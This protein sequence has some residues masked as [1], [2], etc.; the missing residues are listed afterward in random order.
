MK[1]LYAMELYKLWKNKRFLLFLMIL[2]LCN[3]VFLSYETWGQGAVPADAYQKL[4]T[5][6]QSLS[7]N[8][9]FVYIKEH[10]HQVELASVEEQ[11]R[12]LKAQHD[13][14]ADLR[15]SALRDQYPDLSQKV[16]EEPLY[17]G[18]LESESAFMK[19]IS[20][21]SDTVSQYADFLKGIEQK[22][23]MISSISIFAKEDCFSSRNI[24]KSRED[25]AAMQS[26]S[27]DFQ[28]QD[29]LIKALSYPITAVLVILMILLYSTMMLLQERQRKLQP[30]LFCTERGRHAFMNT[31]AVSVIVSSVLVVVLFYGS[32]LILMRIAYGPVKLSAALPSLA[33][34][35]Q[36]TLPISILQFL[37]LFFFLKIFICALLAQVMLLLCTIF[38]HRITCYLSIIA[39]VLLSLAMHI[40]LSPIG[41]F[42]ILYYLNPVRL[43]QV[44]EMLESYV[45]FNVFQQP[46]SLYLMYAAVLLSCALLVFLLQHIMVKRAVSEHRIPAFVQHL[47]L[48][49]ARNLWAQECYKF[50]WV[51][52]IAVVLL[53]FAGFQL[54]SYSHRELYTSQEER[55]WSSYMQT[56]QG[57]LTKEKEAFLQKEKT[58]YKELHKQEERLMKR[59]DRKEITVLQYRKQV[60]P[61][62]NML[63]KEETFSQILQEYE[64]VKQDSSR[65]FV[66]PFGYRHQFFSS[67]HWTILIFLFLFVLSISNLQCSEYRNRRQT[68]LQTTV[69]AKKALVNKKLILALVCGVAMLI[70]ARLPQ[71]LQYMDTYGFPCLNASLTS[72]HEFANM[73]SWISFAVFLFGTAVIRMIAL[74]PIIMFSYMISVNV[75]QQM[76]TLLSTAL[77]FLFPLILSSAGI[78]FLD[79]VS[80]YPL[81]YN[82]TM[83][84][85]TYGMWNL[86]LSLVGYL[87]FSI[88]CYCIARSSEQGMS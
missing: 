74:I 58:Y 22:A 10:A 75:R 37:F 1:N 13:P 41:A 68:L 25:Y 32:N 67:D 85:S 2:L 29:A 7:S 50:F 40:F 59:L 70:M 3:I 12:N 61:I 66:I 44:L 42:R 84:T 24:Q 64:Y 38:Q 8:Q 57:P 17:T 28:L 45:N 54:Y 55:L 72:M 20:E 35:Q 76:F 5:H 79:A 63:L 47:H 83:L 15:I 6:L 53:V 30:M 73:P 62:S 16:Q 14:Q 71:L 23:K 80:L 56:L 81:L 52:K 39:G 69:N 46:V 88:I 49:I 27:I 78:H 34:F 77:V 87:L 82:E 11:I 9:R 18:D 60:E 43:F 19:N 33:A 48:P 21:Q 31:K 26:V 36:S 4:N 65:Q 86:L 51:Q